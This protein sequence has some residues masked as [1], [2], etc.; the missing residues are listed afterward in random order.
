MLAAQDRL[1]ASAPSWDADLASLAPR[2]GLDAV[3]VRADATARAVTESQDA[4]GVALGATVYLHPDRVRPGTAEGREV[5]AHELVHVA[6]SRLVPEIHDGTADRDAAEQEAASLAP[7]IAAG[8]TVEAPRRRID[9]ARPAADRHAKQATPAKVGLDAIAEAEKMLEG[10]ELDADVIVASLEASRSVGVSD[11]AFEPLFE[12]LAKTLLLAEAKALSDPT[13]P[14]SRKQRLPAFFQRL[15]RLKDGVKRFELKYRGNSIV[16]RA[17]GEADPAAPPDVSAETPSADVSTIAGMHDAL[18]G[19]IA[20][21]SVGNWNRAKELFTPVADRFHELRY[22][23]ESVQIL[24]SLGPARTHYELQL[25]IASVA[26]IDLRN[27]LHDGQVPRLMHLAYKKFKIATDLLRVFNGEIAASDSKQIAAV[28]EFARRKLLF[29]Y[30]PALVYIAPYAAPEVMIWASANPNAALALLESSIALAPGI[31][32]AGGPVEFLLS[33][34]D[35][36]AMAAEFAAALTSAWANFHTGR[37][38]D[39]AGMAPAPKTVNGGED[40]GEIVRHPQ[41]GDQDEYQYDKMRPGP[42]TD[43]DAPPK[44]MN[45]SPATGFYGGQYNEIVLETDRALYRVCSA[46]EAKGG[47]AKLGR[48]FTEEPLQSDMQLQ[49]NAA[50]KPVWPDENGRVGEARSPAEVMMTVHVPK[51]TRVYKGPVAAQGMGH[52]GGP[53][54]IQVFIPDIRKT[55]GVAIQVVAPFERHGHVQPAPAN[56]KEAE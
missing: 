10:A 29:V 47:V 43:L 19:A 23:D 45:K 14:E 3:V 12:S 33:H 53:D 27:E 6:Q 52:L 4:R 32:E 42:L 54:Q 24:R 40:V 18:I 34:A 16:A 7:R 38:A 21:A 9:L 44:S 25:D 30:V 37:N 28:E 26:L 35:D 11:E 13:L 46:D 49:I 55:P 31:I 48:W 50:V 20:A 22:A 5:L 2:L 41:R 39:R 56:T 51:G 36:P 15:A 8:E 1:A 17:S